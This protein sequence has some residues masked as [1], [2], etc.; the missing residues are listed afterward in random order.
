MK[1]MQPHPVQPAYHAATGN[2]LPVAM[3]TD[4]FVERSRSCACPNRT[5]LKYTG[6]EKGKPEA[7]FT[8]DYSEGFCRN[9]GPRR[10]QVT[11]N[12]RVVAVFERSLHQPCICAQED[13]MVDVF[14]GAV[15]SPQSHVAHI[16]LQKPLDLCCGGCGG[17]E[18]IR[19]QDIHTK[20]SSVIHAEHC[21]GRLGTMTG[22]GSLAGLRISS[23]HSFI[24]FGSGYHVDAARRPVTD[25][26]KLSIL[27]LVMAADFY[28]ISLQG[29]NSGGN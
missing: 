29:G 27:G 24:G 19:V 8:H 15:P 10:M 12:G 23:E 1:A 21:C 25:N 20:Q 9:M 4:F 26:E 13:A 7:T 5:L 6:K 14:L 22:T 11:E 2:S 3:H 28:I 16:E 17:M 18:E